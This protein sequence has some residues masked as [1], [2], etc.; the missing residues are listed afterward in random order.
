MRIF[1]SVS[2]RRDQLI[3]A[4][5]LL[6]SLL[7]IYPSTASAETQVLHVG[8]EDSYALSNAI[9]YLEDAGGRLTLDGILGAEAQQRF[10][11]LAREREATNF[12]LTPSAF[13]L[14]ATLR[15]QPSAASHWLLEIAYPSLD[16]I[17]LF[18]PRDGGFERQVSGDLLPFTARP[19][20][21]RNHVFPIELASD[22]ARTL[23]IRVESQGTVTVPVRLWQPAALW[24]YDQK[25]YTSLSLYF[26]M[27]M[28]LALYNLLLY[29]SLHDRLY[30]TYVAFAACMAVGQ[31]AMNGFGAQFLWPDWAWWTNVSLP[32]G[33]GATGFFATMFTRDFLSTAIKLPRLDRVLVAL[34]VLF[35]LSSAAALFLPYW[36]S[37]WMIN[38]V[39]V[40]FSVLVVI[41]GVYSL[42]QGHPGA[43]YF[44]LAWS[45]L[46]VSAGAISL[47]N[48]GVL[49]SNILTI[50][51][52]LVGS[53]I[54]MLLLSFALADRINVTLREKVL[55]QAD[56]IAAEQRLSVAHGELE[57][58]NRTLEQTV[59][60]RT[61]HLSEALDFSETVMLNSPLPMRVYAAGGQCVMVNEAYA[62]LMG[63]TREE[64]LAQNF[65]NF[66]SWRK[67][68]LLDDGLTAL[69]QHSPQRREV[70]LL[71]SFGKE[72]WLDYR[73]LPTYLN[74]EDHLLV[75]CVDLTERKRLEEELRH[76]AFHDSLT[77]L[78][79]RRLLLD[80]L[81]Q[82]MRASK[83]QNSHVA[84]LYLD[85]NKFKQLNDAHG[86]DV[87]DRLLIEVA[88]RLRQVVRD[89]D[90]V[91]RLG[92]DE[93]VVLMEGLGE[94]RQPAV[95]YATFVADKIRG[96]LGTEYIFGDTHYLGSVSVGIK[97]F[98]GD[99]GDPDQILKEADTAMYAAK[100][101]QNT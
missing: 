7:L 44:L 14:R 95:E 17:E 8:L 3:A 38:V 77:R 62:H 78:P 88:D 59:A 50:N 52:L 98:I 46:L 84:V 49:P 83:R 41:T 35:I 101:A 40:I 47:H 32:T 63:G 27:L 100:K 53:A 1:A 75:Q 33:M 51:S 4:F 94:E 64:L 85:L 93:F 57:Q 87:G 55:A 22:Q 37:A 28:G 2:G 89:S 73:I 61:Q 72:L 25:S 6:A 90:T 79:N 60:E 9:T 42:C 34:A 30:L 65:R 70:Q 76:I 86:H 26:G 29:F 18:I 96:A 21:H 48:F 36:I 91:A 31:S 45:L 71:T 10:A 16:K 24:Q 20:P 58:I 81:G 68:G 12:G 5:L 92:G 99:E 23:Y 13:W 69:A 80:R 82:A 54:E 11:P 74:G 97:L 19:F 56:A 39:G 43:R 15:R 67:S 66:V